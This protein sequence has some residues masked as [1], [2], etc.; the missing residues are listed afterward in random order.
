M[1]YFIL[2]ET[3]THIITFTTLLDKIKYHFTK[4]RVIYDMAFFINKQIPNAIF[5]SALQEGLSIN[6]YLECIEDSK[7]QHTGVATVKLSYD[8]VKL[9]FSRKAN[10]FFQ[11]Y[12]DANIKILEFSEIKEIDELGDLSFDMVVEI[13]GEIIQI[14]IKVTQNKKN[15][16]VRFL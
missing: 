2:M 7:N 11:N 16:T 12:N 5:A 1:L 9:Y 4:S 8:G 15:F 10:S 13:D 14:E 3:E 6:Q